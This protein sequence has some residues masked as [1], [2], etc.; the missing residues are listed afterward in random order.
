[1]P[2]LPIFLVQSVQSLII[3]KLTTQCKIF[4]LK[5]VVDDTFIKYVIII[6]TFNNIQFWLVT[7]Q[8]YNLT[9]DGKKRYKY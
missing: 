3:K 6:I 4:L 7:K 9:L 5:L 2:T 1:M 8:Y